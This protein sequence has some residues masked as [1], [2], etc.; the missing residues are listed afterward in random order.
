MNKKTFLATIVA[1]VT[2]IGVD[3][4]YFCESHSFLSHLSAAS[5]S[6]SSS[7]S[8][9]SSSTSSI[10]PQVLRETIWE[11]GKKFLLIY[12][13]FNGIKELVNKE[14]L[15]YAAL[16]ESI[17]VL[18]KIYNMDTGMLIKIVYIQTETCIEKPGKYNSSCDSPGTVKKSIDV[19]VV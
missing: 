18:D 6:H 2:L 3:L 14:Q 12:E 17:E 19:K 4:Y 11:A 8:S 9:T 13:I 15:S 16:E 1:L 10:V 5:S 7:S